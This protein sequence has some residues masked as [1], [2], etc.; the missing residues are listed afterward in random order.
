[1]DVDLAPIAVDR[2]A[3]QYVQHKPELLWPLEL[4]HSSE[5]GSTAAAVKADRPERALKIVSAVK[6]IST[7]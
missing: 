1:M 5:C 7:I 4:S 6:C 2:T 3:V